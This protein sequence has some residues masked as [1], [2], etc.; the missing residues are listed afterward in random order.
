MAHRDEQKQELVRLLGPLIP[1]NEPEDGYLNW[2]LQCT[3]YD[4]MKKCAE[5]VAN[6]IRGQVGVGTM[7]WDDDLANDAKYWAQVCA[8]RGGQ[9]HASWEERKHQGEN[10]Y[11][12]HEWNAY[13]FKGA[14]SS[15]GSN[16]NGNVFLDAMLSWTID[17]KFNGDRLSEKDRFDRRTGG[18]DGHY[19]E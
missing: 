16:A 7:V 11:Q 6:L 2:M 5:Y 1:D 4:D 9:Q 8:S 17:N 12:G 14:D 3:S 13:G 18:V 19:S 10:I 15:D